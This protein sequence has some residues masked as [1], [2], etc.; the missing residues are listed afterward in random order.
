MQRGVGSW[1]DIVR[2]KTHLSNATPDQARI[3][4][5]EF[6]NEHVPA[7]LADGLTVGTGCSIWE[8]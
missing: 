6:W 8:N 1:M 7:A 3:F 4:S 5:D 2:S